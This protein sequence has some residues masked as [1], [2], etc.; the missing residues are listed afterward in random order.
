MKISAGNG[1]VRSEEPLR[2][3]C[4]DVPAWA[5]KLIRRLAKLEQGHAYAL[6]IV[7]TDSEP[8]WTVQS[9]GKLENGR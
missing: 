4:P 6:T 8:V 3:E 1:L 5:W 9:V 7:M 2:Y